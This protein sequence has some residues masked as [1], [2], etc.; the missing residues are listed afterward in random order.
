MN[1]WVVVVGGG[2]E[3]WIKVY[4]LLGVTFIVLILFIM[5]QDD[6]SYRRK[7]HEVLGRKDIPRNVFL[8]ACV[9]IIKE[10]LLFLLKGGR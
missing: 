2:D 4:E 5:A 3:V 10:A 8:E 1:L 9:D 7:R 6:V